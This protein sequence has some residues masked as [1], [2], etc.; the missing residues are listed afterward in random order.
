MGSFLCSPT[1]DMIQHSWVL[2]DL[3]V[4]CPSGAPCPWPTSPSGGVRNP[5]GFRSLLLAPC[6]CSCSFRRVYSHGPCGLVH[7]IT[8]VVCFPHR[9]CFILQRMFVCIFIGGLYGGP[10]SL[11]QGAESSPFKIHIHSAS[12]LSYSSRKTSRIAPTSSSTRGDATSTAYAFKPPASLPC[13]WP[14]K[15]LASPGET[16]DSQFR[17]ESP[18]A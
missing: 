15:A 8:C 3:K 5:G 11:L 18:S 7:I 10:T 16:L 14:C 13:T 1:S 4:S 9:G 17:T 6:S 12:Q 2:P